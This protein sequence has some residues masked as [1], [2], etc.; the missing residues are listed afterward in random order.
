M[1]RRARR[2]SSTRRRPRQEESAKK[3]KA[4]RQ[5]QR[6][7][8][9]AQAEREQELPAPPTLSAYID[10]TGLECDKDSANVMSSLN[11]N[12]AVFVPHA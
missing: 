12:A 9:A 6:A 3:A 8:E 2:N 7:I 5:K 4:A 11:P 1:R 10:L